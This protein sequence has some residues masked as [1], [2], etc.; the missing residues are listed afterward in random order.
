MNVSPRTRYDAMVVAGRLEADLAQA[1]VIDQLA[2]LARRLENYAPPRRANGLARLIGFHAAEPPRGLYI[3]GPVG[4]GK[5]LLMDLFYETASTEAKRRVHFH[6][7]MADA[8]E[9]I[10]RWRERRKTDET[11]GDDPIAPVAA[12]LAA[13][14]WLLCF[15]EFS[16]NDIADAMILSRLF[17]ALFAAGAI[18]VATSNVAPDDLYKDGLNRALFLPFIALMRERLDIVELNARADYRLEKLARAPVYYSPADAAAKAALDRAFEALT[19]HARGE[20]VS[21]SFLGRSLEVPE[22]IDGVARFAYADLC[23]MPLGSSDF[24]ALAQR[25]HTVFVDNIPILNPERRDEVKRFIN[26]IDT[27]YDERVKVV[28][29][30][31]VEPAE[32]YPGGEGF[33]AFEFARTASRL[34]EMRS[35]D[36]LALPHGHAGAAVSGDL[37][38]LVET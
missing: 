30:A 14:A 26:L 31:A 29:S 36:Y 32:L 35:A 7:F 12:D 28:A 9:R 8:H 15:D 33:E 3:Y 34:I 10:H 2:A 11:A 5:S 4:R 13:E 24:L 23:R 19:G 37:G 27:L 6:A 17:T 25:F 18:V 16:V 21:V 22:A 20:P 38:G 1:A